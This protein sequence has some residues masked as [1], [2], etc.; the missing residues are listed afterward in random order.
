MDRACRSPR[1]CRGSGDPALFLDD[2]DEEE[3]G[4]DGVGDSDEKSLTMMMGR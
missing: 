2:D 4:G 3:D 1:R